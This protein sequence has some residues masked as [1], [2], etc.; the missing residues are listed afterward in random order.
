MLCYASDVV[1]Q[2]FLLPIHPNLFLSKD[3]RVQV[4]RF[5]A[6]VPEVLRYVSNA[7]GKTM[8]QNHFVS[9]IFAL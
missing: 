4:C 7:K 2:K 1:E 9:Y 3:L 6:N 8:Y 5:L